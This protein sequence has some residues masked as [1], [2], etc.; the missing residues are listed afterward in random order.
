[1]NL[2]H[3]RITCKTPNKNAHIESFHR[4]LEGCISKNEYSSYAEDY[5]S[6]YEI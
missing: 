5:K 4:L 3:E 1:M 2:E 6:V